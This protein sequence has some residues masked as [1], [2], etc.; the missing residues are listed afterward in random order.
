MAAALVL[1]TGGT[2]VGNGRILATW[3]FCLSQDHEP[4]PNLTM[5][6]VSGWAVMLGALLTLGALLGRLP[7]SRRY[8]LPAMLAAVVVL[9]W[10]YVAGMGSPAPLRPG[11]PPESVCRVLPPFPFTG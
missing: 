1:A 8:R 6:T 9:T 4:N 2:L 7:R 10:L 11:Q 5:A 3:R